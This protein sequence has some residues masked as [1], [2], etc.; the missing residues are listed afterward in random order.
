LQKLISTIQNGY[1]S[2]RL[3]NNDDSAHFQDKLYMQT[4][5]DTINQY[6]YMVTNKIDSGENF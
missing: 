3:T 6:E 5:K 1:Y 2:L 4:Y